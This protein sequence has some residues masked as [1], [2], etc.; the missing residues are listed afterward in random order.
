VY[1]NVWMRERYSGQ[2]VCILW[3]TGKLDGG[4]EDHG[5]IAGRFRTRY[6]QLDALRVFDDG[7]P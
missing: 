3:P 5:N 6:A 1:E 4:Q 7:D 2:D